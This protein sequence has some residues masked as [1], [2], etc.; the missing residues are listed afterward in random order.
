MNIY[1]ALRDEFQI[2]PFVDTS[3]ALVIGYPGFISSYFKLIKL[4]N[5]L[6]FV[7]TILEE[8]G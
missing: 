1:I 8:R 3:F 7:Y 2:E 4:E 5:S 6:E